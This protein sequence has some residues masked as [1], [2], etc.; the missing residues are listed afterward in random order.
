MLNPVYIIIKY[1]NLIRHINAYQLFCAYANSPQRPGPCVS[2]RQQRQRRLQ[3]RAAA[4]CR[5]FQA[6]TVAA[7]GQLRR[8][9]IQRY[10]PGHE[11]CL[12]KSRSHAFGQTY[13]RRHCVGKGYHIPRRGGAVSNRFYRRP[14]PRPAHRRGIPSVGKGLEHIPRLAQAQTEHIRLRPGQVADG[15]NP[16]LAK[17]ARGA[18]PHE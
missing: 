1:V 17:T 9:H 6:H 3:Q 11:S 4:I 15:V 5:T 13:Q 12:P 10:R 16:Q 14:L 7:P 8:T 2:L 18:P